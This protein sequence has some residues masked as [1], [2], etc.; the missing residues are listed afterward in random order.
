[1][2]TC[3]VYCWSFVLQ[4]G[5]PG[6]AEAQPGALLFMQNHNM[7]V[8]QLLQG[9]ADKVSFDAVTSSEL[10]VTLLLFQFTSKYFLFYN[11]PM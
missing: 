7:D 8:P 5:P 1:M 3:C 11:V 9:E 4:V 2:W 10:V 6:D